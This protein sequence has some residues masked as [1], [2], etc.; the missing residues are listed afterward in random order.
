MG[1]LTTPPKNIP[2]MP[3]NDRQIKAAKP[4]DTGKKAKLFD[5]GGLYL[6]V[7]PAGGKVFRLKY[8]I[9][10]K[11]KTLTIGK[12]PT[13]S[14]VEA[15]QAADSARRMIAQEQDPSAMKQQAKQERKTALLNTFAN[16]T[17]A[18]HEKTTKRKSW[19]P[20][21]AARVLRYFETDVFPIIGETPINK[22]GK[23]EIKAVLDK[24][25]ERGVSE[26]AEKIRQWI[27]AV[28]TYAG[29]EELTDRNPAALLKGYIEPT[30]SKR[31]P[32]LPREEL[33]EFYRRLIL[34]DCEQQN[35]ICVMLIM[36]CFAR[37]K[38]IR[39]GQWQEID[40]KRK[41]WT[42][43]ANRMKRP[44]DH[45]IPLSDWAIELLNELHAITGETPFLFPSPKSETGY[46][47]ENTAGKI[48]NGMGYYGIATPHGFRSLASSV[49]N[50]QGFN[51]DAIERQLAH[52]ENNKIRAAY[53]RAD[54]LNE[55]KEFMQWYS[56]FLRERYNQALQMIQKDKTD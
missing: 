31:M 22:I 38:E 53:N 17:K 29:Y 51:P 23:K 19:K 39:G 4:S 7:T 47:S 49:L 56:D 24:V 34:A 48:I 30:E 40:F 52:I 8:R 46:I 9:D 33:P 25:T 32:A 44:R 3:L 55:R 41:T 21:H 15:R 37:N 16:V 28:F 45:T 5:G 10:G 36:L 54:Y 2:P 14:L 50:E 43:P 12:Y 13:V 1:N 11:E 20:N 18:W 6:E 35:R 42:I 26:T 27:G